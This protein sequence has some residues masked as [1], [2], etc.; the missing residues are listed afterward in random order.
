MLLYFATISTLDNPSM[1]QSNQTMKKQVTKSLH[2][3]L[4]FP[5]FT[6]HQCFQI[7][8]LPHNTHKIKFGAFNKMRAQCSQVNV[9]EL[10]FIVPPSFQWS[11][12]FQHLGFLEGFKTMFFLLANLNSVAKKNLEFFWGF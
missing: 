11:N 3:I 7:T 4:M 8:T 6:I 9:E 10:M 5:P 12:P 1:L 2:N